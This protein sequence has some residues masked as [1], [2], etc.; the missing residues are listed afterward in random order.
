M[1]AATNPFLG[2]STPLTPMG[3]FAGDHGPMVRVESNA[4]RIMEVPAALP[5]ESL[6]AL[7]GGTSWLSGQFP[8]VVTRRS[9]DP[10]ASTISPGFCQMRAARALIDACQHAEQVRAQRRKG[11]PA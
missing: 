11:A 9:Y 5:A 4:G 6:K 7:C 3:Y 8:D 2:L 10:H 1:I